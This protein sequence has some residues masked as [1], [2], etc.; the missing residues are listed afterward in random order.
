MLALE[1]EE[2][3]GSLRVLEVALQDVRMLAQ[4]ARREC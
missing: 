3:A 4:K 1:Y 2:R